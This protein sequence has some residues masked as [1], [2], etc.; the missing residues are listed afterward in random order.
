MKRQFKY[1]FIIFMLLI[2][3]Q[4]EAKQDGQAEE[5][6]RQVSTYILN[7]GT[8]EKYEFFWNYDFCADEGSPAVF[9]HPTLGILD[10][11]NPQEEALEDGFSGIDSIS[12]FYDSKTIK[13]ADEILNRAEF[14]KKFDSLSSRNDKVRMIMKE[15]S[16][17]MTWDKEIIR[18]IEYGDTLNAPK[19]IWASIKYLF[20]GPAYPT[21]GNYLDHKVGVCSTFAAFANVLSQKAGLKGIGIFSGAVTDFDESWGFHA[22]SIDFQTGKQWSPQEGII[23][24]E[25]SG[26]PRS[27]GM[28]YIKQVAR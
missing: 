8:K 6:I 13:K 7:P 10:I 11:T 19:G 12:D 3:T 20:N 25:K 9:L 26:Y 28:E 27:F 15:V 17:S 5:C 16:K 2:S 22:W 14:K 21:L 4:L 23:W 24:Y 1:Y 18:D